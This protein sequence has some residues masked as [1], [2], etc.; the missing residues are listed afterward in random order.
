MNKTEVDN[1]LNRE[2]TNA[3]QHKCV[4][5]QI[6]NKFNSL[7]KKQRELAIE[8]IERYIIASEKCQLRLDSAPIK[9]II[10]DAIDGRQIW[11]ETDNQFLDRTGAEPSKRF[12]Q[13]LN[14]KSVAFA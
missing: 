9:E 1:I 8:G 5:K 6:I 7:T 12:K 11:K 10:E 4:W 13:K 2:F 3:Y 14:I